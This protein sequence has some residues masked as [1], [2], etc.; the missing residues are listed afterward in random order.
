MR[1]GT[2]V[3]ERI[4]ASFGPGVLAA[5]G[6]IDRTALGEVV[7]GDPERR[8]VLNGLVHPE[9]K[10]AWERWLSAQAAHP[11]AVVIIPL[12]Y[13]IGE[14]RDWDA[15]ICVACP[16][17][18]QISRLEARGLSPE[19]AGLRLA[20]QMPVADKMVRADHVI[21]NAGSLE[22]LEEQT[23]RVWRHILET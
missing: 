16:G 13:E 17:R 4:L 18:V 20:A 2:A 5:S 1:R 19:Q 12:L 8:A 9:V 21:F 7:F 3:Y 14:E 10:Q 15:V 11:A 23:R 6:E 22:E